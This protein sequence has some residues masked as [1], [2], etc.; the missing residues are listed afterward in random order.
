MAAYDVDIQLAVKNLNTIKALKKEL[1]AVEQALEKISKLDTF[2][3]SGFRARSK[4][5]QDEKDQIKDQ[6]RLTNDLKRAE[7]ARRADLLRGVRL[8]RQQRREGLQ[9]YTGP[10]GPGAAS[11]VGGRIRQMQ[12]VEQLTKAAFAAYTQLTS[13]AKAHDNNVT[14]IELANDDVVFKQ[15]LAQIDQAADAELK[16]AKTTNAEALK[17]FDRRLNNR[18]TKRKNSLFGDATGKERAGAAVSAGAFPLLF[19]GG[20]GMAIGGAIG[21]AITGSTFGPA[22]IALQV[23][24][25]FVDEL[26]AKAA[27]LGQAL[28]LATADVNAVVESLGLAGSPVQDAIQSLEELAG[29]QVALEEATKQLSLV[30]GDEGVEALTAFGD[31][32]TRFGN[33]LTKTTTQILAQI[34]RLSGP[35]VGRI[36]QALEFQTD[37]SA[38]KASKDPRQALLQAQLISNEKSLLGDVTGAGLRRQAGIEVEMVGLQRKIKQEEEDRLA[39]KVETTRIGSVEHVIA[40]NNLAISKLEGDLTNT[41]IFNLEKANIMQEAIGKK[42]REGADIKLI[43][44][45]RETR[46]QDLTSRRDDQIEA[47]NKKANSAATRAQKDADRLAEKKERAIERAIKGADRELERA[48]KAFDRANDQLDKIIQKNEDKMAFEREYA[49]LIRNGSTPAA[50][51]QA[52]ELKKQQLEL[53][54]NFEKLKEQLVLQLE[55]AKAAILTAK[56]RGASG[57]ELDALNKDLADLL[58]KIDKLPGKKE[59]AEGAITAALSPKSE[60]QEL[61]NYLTD[62]Q[63]QINDLNDPVQRIIGLA[64]TLGGAFSESF[65]GIV[66]GSMTAREALANLFQRTAD[67]FLDMAAQMIAAQ[68]KMQLLN[69][70]LSFFGGG[71]VGRVPT[72]VPQ[73]TKNAIVTP[74]GFSGQ[75]GGFA[76]NGGPVTGGNS[77]IV[78]ERGPELFVPGA[79]GNIVP[80]HAMGGGANVTVN[81]DASGSNVQGDQ[82]DAKALGSA[83]GA[84]VQAEL[85]KQKRPGGLLSA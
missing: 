62:L 6:I 15:K 51:K 65:K 46:L 10:I 3:P 37:L 83:I 56:A 4:A 30:V 59:D 79:K 21:G 47:A 41:R 1:D 55:V 48:D 53:D 28:N 61:L 2:D 26:A 60:R 16:A 14:K 77:Y 22:S 44:I 71:G 67:H 64:E 58:G 20:P 5:R 66:S 19:G 73:M 9:Q 72:Q 80:N 45:E 36:T 7:S 24:G 11:P 69:I 52:I 35:V 57:T 42:A 18:V 75:F 12:E 85:I 49:E 39:V 29:E 40:K 70:G 82:P 76:A 63:G 17:D 31:V 13:V 84:A 50:A 25:G 78:G 68:I 54:R 32:S 8:E 74:T 33:A 43:D 81:V 38:A 23:L 34:A 27:T